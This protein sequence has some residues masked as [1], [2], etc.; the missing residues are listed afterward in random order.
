MRS[1]KFLAA[2]S[3]G[4][5]LLSAVIGLSAS[6][7]TRAGWW[8]YETGLK[9]LSPGVIIAILGSVSGAVW[10]ARALQIN[11][12]D[13]WRLG[14]VGLAGS[15]VVAIIPLNQLRLYFSLPPIHDIS[16][17]VE[18][19]PAYSAVLPLRAGA[20]NG[21]DYDGMNLVFF[22][23]RMTHVSAAQ[24]KAYPDIRAYLVLEK[25]ATLFWHGFEVAKRMTGWNI[26]AFD[27][28]SGMI[29]AT[30]TSFWFGLTSDIAIRVK[31]AG[32]IGARL[33]IRAKSR[34]GENDMGMNA[35]IVRDY[36]RAL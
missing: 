6:H 32:K 11:D 12:S 15:L 28:K 35:A 14:A 23:G 34:V 13:G 1:Q 24:K 4:S 5:F 30:T 31:P 29:E 20:A 10:L 18:F 21:S 36:R 7:G 16:T 8:S 33:D 25:P 22:G 19:A 3:L 17:D 2:A 9:I 27:E 26:V